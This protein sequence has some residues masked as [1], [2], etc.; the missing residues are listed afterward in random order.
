MSPGNKQNS[1][2]HFI[3]GLHSVNDS[4]VPFEQIGYWIDGAIRADHLAN[5]ETLLALGRS[6][7]YPAID[8]AQEN[9]FIVPKYLEGA[10]PGPTRS[11]SGH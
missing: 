1:L 8:N 6:K 9:G 3:G 5:N 10:L 11:I 2:E 4:W 7:I